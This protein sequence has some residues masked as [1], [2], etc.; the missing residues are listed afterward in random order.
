ML[1]L[2]KGVV[3]DVCDDAVTTLEVVIDLMPDEWR[4]LEDSLSF[5]IQRLLD[6]MEFCN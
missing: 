6:V 5:G 2:L 4:F 3:Y 1:D